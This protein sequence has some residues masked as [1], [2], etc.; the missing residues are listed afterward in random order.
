M[1]TNRHSRAHLLAACIL[2]SAGTLK[3]Q[4]ILWEKSYGG[5][6][7]DYLFD[8]QPTP[9]YG[10]ILA[11]SSLSKNTG[12]KTDDNNGNLD[13]FIWKM[14]EKGELDWQKGFGGTGADLLQSIKLTPDGGFIL[15]GTSNSPKGLHKKDDCKGLEDFWIIKLNAK[16]TEQW[17]RTI[18]GTGQELLQSIASTS[19]GGYIIGG[20]SGSSRSEKEKNGKEDMF[21]KKEDSRGGL[22]YWIV[23]LDNEGQIEW[24]KTIGGQYSDELR[25]IIQTA[26]GGFMLAGS[27]NSTVSG[28]KTEKRYGES[29]YW[30]VKTDKFGTIEW[31][32]VYGGEGD[33]QLKTMLHT[34]DGNYILAGN[35]ASESSGN[36]NT[37]NTNGIDFWLLK[38]DPSGEILWQETYDVGKTD[39]LASLVE[40]ED[41]SFLIGGHA[42]S[43]TS[44]EKKKDKE[45]INDYVA[46]KINEKGEEQWRKTVG[47]N[48]QD[49]LR[50]AVRVRDGGYLLAGTSKG[51]NSRD[52]HSSQGRNDFW[53]VKLKN[54]KK[55]KEEKSPIE[56]F[57]NPTAQFTN[58]IVGYE[59]EKGTATVFDLSG[60]QLQHFDIQDRTVPVD[61][62]G[63]PIG[64][65]L[66]QIR[67]N[68]QEDT[69][70]I[71]K[72]INKK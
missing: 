48:G 54:E 41:G 57:P 13:Y 11:G 21:E 52:R 70:K 55:K 8:A 29:D 66:V 33:E 15:A 2:L 20:T 69:V 53:V 64:I 62:G 17:Q 38:I 12:N 34:S 71:V 37:S 31:Q 44:S 4:D 23:K 45:D 1:A 42:M 7:S 50:K 51:S 24:Q 36:K 5:K 47:S 56:A 22:D 26:D 39:L 18:G 16:G 35:S 25:S 58:V 3:A 30:V 9:D 27:S 32:K 6:H 61:L 68:V 65:Y 63:L 28:D 14:D 59:F 67:T 10:F 40:N 19:D 49:I 43:E 60:R 46:I 72:A